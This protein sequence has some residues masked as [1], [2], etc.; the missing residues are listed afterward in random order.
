MQGLA[1]E[2]LQALQVDVLTGLQEVVQGLMASAAAAMAASAP[3]NKV[4]VD[5]LVV[6]QAVP[7]ASLVAQALLLVPVELVDLVPALSVGVWAQV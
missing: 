4:Q 5:G 1:E 7:A 6:A 2:V 3:W